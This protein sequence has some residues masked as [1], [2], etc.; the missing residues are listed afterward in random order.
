MIDKLKVGK[1]LKELRLNKKKEEG[2]ASFSKDDLANEF[3]K[4]EQEISINAIT[5]WENGKSLP[6]LENLKI[7]SEIYNKTLDEILDG[8]D[9]FVGNFEEKYFIHNQSWL[10][11]YSANNLYQIGKEQIK[12]ITARFKELLVI[13]LKRLFTTNEENEFEFLFRNYYNL[14]QYGEEYSKLEINDHYLQFKDALNDLVS[15]I[16]NMSLEEKYWEVQKLY[17]EKD[18]IQFTF[19][20]DMYDLNNVPIIV[21]RLKNIEDW[22]KDMLLAMFQNIE[23]H[24]D[25]PGKYG[26]KHYKKYE[27]TRGVYDHERDIKN[28]IR[29][30]IKYGACINKYYL[31]VKKESIETKRIIDRV[32]ELFDLCLKPIEVTI[33]KNGKNET[34]LIENNEKNRFINSYYCYLRYS[35]K[36]I[37]ND[38][39][40]YEDIDALFAWFLSKDKINKDD[41]LKIAKEYKIDI[42]NYEEKYW[43]SEVKQ[44]S[45]IDVWFYKFKEKEREIASGLIELKE[46]KS[47]LDRGEI[48]YFEKKYEII[49]GDNESSIRKYIQWI[50]TKMDYSEYIKCRNKQLTKQLLSDLDIL[51]LDEIKN[52]YFKVEV[53]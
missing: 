41:Y 32:Q 6:S 28:N 13:R 39:G 22:Q 18:I 17:C 43:I 1:Y 42:N 15:E 5:E 4:N 20:S 35:L 47:K 50:N 25:N 16:R 9:L 44:Q 31:N 48:E 45:Q 51:S 3:I 53:I 36:R 8:E 40:M 38:E 33:R 23:P 34:Y 10:S 21:E 19:R 24:G 26:A 12:L 29:K 7:L 11:K 37:G 30:L 52:K 27:E 46:L 2:H 14:S 49:G